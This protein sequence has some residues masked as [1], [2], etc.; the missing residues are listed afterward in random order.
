MQQTEE[1]VLFR[2]LHQRTCNPKRIACFENSERTV[3][4]YMALNKVNK[5]GLDDY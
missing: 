3:S 2:G 5:R 4:E 1:I